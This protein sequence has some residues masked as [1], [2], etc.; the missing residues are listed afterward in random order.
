MNAQRQVGYGVL[1][2]GNVAPL[3]L[4]AIQATQGARLVGVCS[5]AAAARERVATRCEVPAFE[6]LSDLLHLPDLDVLC[7]CT[8]SGQ[9]LEPTLAAARAGK[10][11]VVEKPLE[12]DLRRARRMINACREAGVTLTCI[13]QNRFS[14]DYQN[15]LSKIEAG[16]FGRLVLGNAY[17]KWYRDEAYYAERDWR[18]TLRGDGGAA[19]INQSIHTIDLLLGA[20][21]NVRSVRGRVKTLTHDIEGEDVGAAVL[22]FA[23]GALGTIE[24]STAVFGA[25]DER[26]EIHGSRGSAICEAGRL[27]ELRTDS[28]RVSRPNSDSPEGGARDPGAIDAELHGRQY[29][30]ITAALSEG[31]VPRVDGESALR[32]LEVVQA[33]YES[34]RRGR[35]IQ[36]STE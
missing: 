3:H 15:L 13:F 18:G 4:A 34:S 2:L 25:F 17:V 9:H 14:S 20:L 16:D 1:G 6:H 21:G 24:G 33:I 35:E 36:L 8:P 27:V 31:R 12:V 22:E 23:S 29:A 19:L 10:H 5:R 7:I 11:V 28:E 26:L 30:D 32:A